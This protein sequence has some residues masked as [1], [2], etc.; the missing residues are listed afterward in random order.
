MQFKPHSSRT[1]SD[2]TDPDPDDIFASAVLTANFSD[3][4]NDEPSETE[5]DQQDLLDQSFVESGKAQIRK[6]TEGENLI[7]D[8][9]KY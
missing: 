7:Y 9:A 4:E 1:E 5:S 8:V 2:L 6:K 3:E